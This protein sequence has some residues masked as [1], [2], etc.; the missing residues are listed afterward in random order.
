LWQTERTGTGFLR[1]AHARQAKTPVH[2]AA[3]R[4]GRVAARAAAEALVRRQAAVIAAPGGVGSA[5]AAKAA[6]S[7][8]P[9]VIAGCA[10]PVKLGL[11]AS[12]ARPGG[13]SLTR[14]RSSQFSPTRGAVKRG[15][16]I[17]SAKIVPHPEP[18]A[19][20]RVD[21]IRVGRVAR[22]LRCVI[23]P[24]SRSI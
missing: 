7:T 23:R 17:L 11:V 24:P 21:N 13:N 9:I 15:P 20:R 10:D 8:I 3:W 5:L 4:R 14:S 2:H 16:R 18:N 12:L 22:A 1:E 6:T 19:F